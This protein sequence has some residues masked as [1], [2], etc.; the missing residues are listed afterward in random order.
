VVDSAVVANQTG[1]EKVGPVRRLDLEL[2]R[3]WRER[4]WGAFMR[5]WIVSIVLAAAAGF[6]I[7]MVM[8]GAYALIS[9]VLIR[10][11]SRF[12]ADLWSV[13]LWISALAGFFTLIFTVPIMALKASQGDPVR[14]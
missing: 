12:L 9:I 14:R 8:I 2:E 7:P 1:G 10:S 4:R 3:T 6:V 11:D 13:F 5:A